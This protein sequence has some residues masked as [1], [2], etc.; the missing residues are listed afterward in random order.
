MS[1]INFASVSKVNKTEIRLPFEN[2]EREK[3]YSQL[4]LWNIFNSM[5][6]NQTHVVCLWK[7]ACRVLVKLWWWWPFF[8]VLFSIRMYCCKWR[9]T[10]FN[11]FVQKFNKRV[12]TIL[13]YEKKKMKMLD[14]TIKAINENIWYQRI[15]RKFC[16][17]WTCF[18]F[19]WSDTERTI[20]MSILMS[21]IFFCCCCVVFILCSEK[22]YMRLK[23]PI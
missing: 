19:I 16:R 8:Y 22:M 1:W 9:L 23:W 2:S 4:S 18:F 11:D 15:S 3:E 21:W 5:H 7:I 14:N 13:S 20:D 6:A 17:L 12:N 10:E